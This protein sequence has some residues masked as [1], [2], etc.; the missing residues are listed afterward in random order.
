ME[1]W[2]G[3]RLSV[4][5]LAVTGDGRLAFSVA[6]DRTMVVWDLQTRREVAAVALEGAPRCVAI[7]PDRRKILVGD[8][9]GGVYC[10]RYVVPG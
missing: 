1:T 4:R 9:A 7:T 8:T 5:G 3:H 6:I 2:T 10:L